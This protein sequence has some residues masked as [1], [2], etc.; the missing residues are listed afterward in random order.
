MARAMCQGSWLDS[1]KMM[2][3]TASIAD[4]PSRLLPPSGWRPQ[5]IPAAAA[6]ASP[7][8]MARQP[9]TNEEGEM[10]PQSMQTA[11]M[12]NDNG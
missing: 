11:R 3:E 12:R 7:M 2:K 4:D 5:R 6:A 10:M 8:P 1:M 9:E